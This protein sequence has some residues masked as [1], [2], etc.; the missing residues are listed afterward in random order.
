MW[1]YK[2]LSIVLIVGVFHTVGCGFK[3]LYRTGGNQP[4]VVKQFSQIQISPIE[5]RIGQQLRNLLQDKITPKGAPGSPIYRLVVTLKETRNNLAI[6]QNA[7][8]T[9]AKIR[10]QASFKLIKISSK[11]SL[12]KGTTASIAVFNIN[13]SEYGNIKAE[14]GA[15]SRA[16]EE[17]S[18]SIRTRLALFLRAKAE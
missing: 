16:A 14:A 15:K 7:T 18:E 3:P 2:T 9:F 11:R 5:N 4:N 1:S 12:V 6:L 17:I 10:V 8:S 13:E